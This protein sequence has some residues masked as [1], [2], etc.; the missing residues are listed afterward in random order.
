MVHVVRTTQPALASWKGAR[1]L[2]LGQV[3]REGRVQA[4]ALQRQQL[5]HERHVRAHRR[6]LLLLAL[7]QVR[8]QALRVQ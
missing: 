6:R 7:P 2:R 3:L 1:D 4:R 8:I 5:R